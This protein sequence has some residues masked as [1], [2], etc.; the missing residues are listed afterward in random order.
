MSPRQKQSLRKVIA[1]LVLITVCALVLI[2]L[3]MVILASFRKGNFP[4]N[5]LW[6]S[7]DQWT[8]DHWKYVLGIPYREVINAAT[9][10]TRLIQP[11]TPPL[12]WFFNSIL[13][14]SF[15]SLGIIL[16]AGTAA[17]AFARMRFHF[18]GPTLTGLL[19]L[20]MFP[21]VLTLTAYYRILSLIGQRVPWLGLNTFPGIILIYLSGISINI[22]MIKGYFDTISVSMEESARID[23]ASRFQTFVRILLP[24]S[25]PIFA[26]VFIL[27]FIGMISEYPTASV[28]LQESAVRTLAV[29]AY[30][31]VGEQEK[32][33]GHF[34]ALAVLSG[35]PITIM[36]L[37]CQRFIIGGLTSGGAKE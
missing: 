6:L 9:G 26:V 36:F 27:S 16:L 3:A 15:A 21:Q 19:I 34:S 2:P 35:V 14:S 10:E 29:G 23:G 4:P 17:Y 12:H 18:R 28:I 33:W 22:W 8:L 20:Q 25:A 37:L 31:L 11:E 24:M 13:V 1:H 32:L 7:P 5:A 30:S